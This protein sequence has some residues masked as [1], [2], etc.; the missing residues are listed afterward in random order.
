MK[1]SN[2][3]YKRSKD[4]EFGPVREAKAVRNKA[5]FD[6]FR[7]GFLVHE[8][9]TGQVVNFT[10]SM[11]QIK[12][13]IAKLEANENE[14]QRLAAAVESAVLKNG[15]SPRYT[16]PDEKY[17]DLF[18]PP[19][20]K[21]VL[22][23]GLDGKKHYYSEVHSDDGVALYTMKN[24][25]PD[26]WT[27]LYLLYDGWM[28]NVGNLSDKE[29]R[30]E[31][32]KIGVPDYR[33][34]MSDRLDEALSN[35]E[36]WANPYFAKFLGRLEE[37]QVHN[38][39]IREAREEQRRMERQEREQR[40]EEQRR[41]EQQDY[42]TAIQSAKISILGMQELMNTDIRNTSL[43]LQLFREVGVEVPLKTQGWIKSNLHSIYFHDR[44][45]SCS[46]R[47]S[48]R[49]STVFYSYL[50]KLVDAVVAEYTQTIEPQTEVD[51]EDEDDFER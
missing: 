10:E 21:D 2:V 43:I 26:P 1:H 31:E 20:K 6:L 19:E 46:Y 32:Y 30:I 8:G 16:R 13:F 11:D 29:A 14:R 40:E 33:Q 9:K 18:P 15:L 35:P 36:K 34:A 27:A 42:E 28:I 45:G 7:I 51:F 47:Y 25:K 3:F 37:A 12:A 38:E 22:A 50:D 4:G 24:K 48:G 17:D 44:D 41:Q 5:G 23:P 39:P 49:D